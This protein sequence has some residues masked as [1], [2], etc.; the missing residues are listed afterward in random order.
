MWKSVFATYILFDSSNYFFSSPVEFSDSKQQE[1]CV[2]N[3]ALLLHSF[4]FKNVNFNV[5]VCPALVYW[6]ILNRISTVFRSVISRNHLCYN[7]FKS[8]FRGQTN[9]HGTACSI[10][11]IKLPVFYIFTVGF[12]PQRKFSLLVS[13]QHTR[14]KFWI[15]TEKKK[16]DV[17]KFSG[18]KSSTAHYF[19]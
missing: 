5:Q 6:W 17:V 7:T 8:N 14:T 4:K 15:E 13:I 3:I 12:E 19:Y 2:L 9:K 18:R 11:M 1:V 16:Q 10:V